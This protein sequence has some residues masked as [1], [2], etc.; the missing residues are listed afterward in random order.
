[1]CFLF[2]VAEASAVALELGKR[3]KEA[4]DKVMLF[5]SR[6]GLF[7]KE[8]SEYES[9]S[10]AKKTFEPF[11]ALWRS[12]GEWMANSEAWLRGPFKNIDAEACETSVDNTLQVD[13]RHV[14]FVKVCLTAL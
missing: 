5:N 12:A 7:N 6:E 3:M 11:N 2:Q 14:L 10:R 9:L 8:V 1:M 4:E 13:P